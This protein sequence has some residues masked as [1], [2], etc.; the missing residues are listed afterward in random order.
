MHG[1]FVLIL[2]ACVGSFLN[3]V[4]LRLPKLEPYILKRSYCPKCG[5][6][7]SFFDLFPILSWLFLRFKCRYCNLSIPFRYPLI[8]IIT[9]FLFLLCFYDRNFYNNL[10]YELFLLVSSWILVSYLIVLTVIDIDEMILPDSLTFSGSIIGFLLILI[11]KFFYFDY[12]SV[13]LEDH[14]FAY[15]FSIIGFFIFSKVVFVAFNKPA[16]GGGDIKLFAMC[17]AW[18]GTIGLELT[19]VLSFLIS[20][21]YSVIALCLNLIRRG[22]YIP[23]GPF[24]CVSTF[25]VWI[26]GDEFWIK[27]LGNILWWK[28]L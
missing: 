14:F 27:S 1:L 19:I 26:L 21:V 15:I 22:D 20:A 17:G 6:K 2:G 16:F 13:K 23:F 3:V 9:S 8:E 7:L 18:L 4:I 12:N 10:S 11:T 5:E 28:Y 25:L 24:I